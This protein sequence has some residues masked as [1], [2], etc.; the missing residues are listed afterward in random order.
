MFSKIRQW[1]SKFRLLHQDIELTNTIRSVSAQEDPA[2][3]ATIKRVRK[4]FEAQSERM[5][6]NALRPHSALCKDPVTCSKKRCFVIGDK[7]V[8]KPYEVELK[9]RKEKD[10]KA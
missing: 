7:I 10:G 4:A 9:T 2:T 5:N 1:A 6:H 3:I 8:S